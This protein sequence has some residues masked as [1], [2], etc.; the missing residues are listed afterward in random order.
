ME[1]VPPMWTY[2]VLRADL[3]RRLGV[4]L[5]NITDQVLQ[6]HFADRRI[7]PQ[8]V[9]NWQPVADA[10]AGSTTAW[11]DTVDVLMYAAGTWVA[12]TSEI[13]SVES[14]YDAA[15]LR[16]NDFTALF[17]EES[18]LTARRGHDSRVIT[19]PICPSGQTAGGVLIDCDG[20]LV[21]PENGDEPGN[22]DG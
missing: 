5:A 7:S 3:S 17:T 21:D 13:I 22:G 6:S 4:P 10:S 15:L 14:L 2:G 16:Q 12:G 20:S 1:I 18:V 19:V 11:P 9:Y 8:F